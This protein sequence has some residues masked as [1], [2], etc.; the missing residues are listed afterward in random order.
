VGPP[1]MYGPPN[2]TGHSESGSADIETF[3]LLKEA[4]AEVSTETC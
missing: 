3:P 2:A 4:V 1:Y